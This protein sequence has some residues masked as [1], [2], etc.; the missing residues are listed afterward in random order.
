MKD[1]EQDGR[2]QR[3][4]ELAESIREVMLDESIADAVDALVSVL[5]F[6]LILISVDLNQAKGVAATVHLEVC[7][8]I[9]KHFESYKDELRGKMN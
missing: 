3:V 4:G 7:K 1:V 8:A 9:E 5:V 6:H 2:D